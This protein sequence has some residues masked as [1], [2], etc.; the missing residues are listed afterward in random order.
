MKFAYKFILFLLFFAF[1]NNMAAQNNEEK[2]AAQ[3]FSN[4]EYDKAA[5]LYE[6]LLNKNLTSFYFYDNLLQSYIKLKRFDDAESLC[7]KMYRKLNSAY[8]MVD[9]GKKGEIWKCVKNLCYGHVTQA[10]G[11]LEYQIQDYPN[12]LPHRDRGDHKD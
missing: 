5:D 12:I 4:A 9:I 2:L 6:K 11:H 7:K 3:F 1:G 10:Y 8:Y